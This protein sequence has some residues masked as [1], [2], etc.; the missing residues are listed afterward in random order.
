MRPVRAAVLLL[1]LCLTACGV[2]NDLTKPNGE[3]TPRGT[4]DP[5]KPPVQLGR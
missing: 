5:S 3:T 4:Q 1:A 2:K